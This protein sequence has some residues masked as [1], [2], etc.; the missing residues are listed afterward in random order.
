MND[1]YRNVVVAVDGSKQSEKAFSEAL[2]VAKRNGAKL[3]IAAI[4]ND[5]E[6]STSAFSYSKLL[7]QEKERMETEVLKKIHDAAINDVN[8]SVP[9]VEVGNPKQL[10]VDYARDNHID[11]IVMGTTGKGALAQ[12]AVGSTTSYVVSHAPCNVLVVR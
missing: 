7:S 9:Y 3:H 2:A 6:L 4:I 1:D 10:I 8:D 11:L 12:Q 5:A